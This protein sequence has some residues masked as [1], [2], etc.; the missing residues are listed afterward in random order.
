MKQGAGRL[1]TVVVLLGFAAETRAA[2]QMTFDNAT[3]AVGGTTTL[4]VRIFDT[5]GLDISSYN[6]DFRIQRLSGSGDLQFINPQ[7][8]SYRTS[9]NNYVFGNLAFNDLST[10]QT[11]GGGTTP[12]TFGPFQR[13]FGADSTSD[14]SDVHVMNSVLLA[15]LQL[16][17]SPTGG[18]APT[19]G[20]TFK[21]YYV[22]TSGGFDYS[23]GQ[24]GNFAPVNF[25]TVTVVGTQLIPEPP[26]LVLSIIAVLFLLPALPLYWR[27]HANRAARKHS[28]GS[29]GT[30]AQ[31]LP[32]GTS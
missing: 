2:F 30:D 20:S 12:N 21:I 5:V 26:S 13:Y 19:V 8:L 14:F 24:P 25:G 17:A 16:T 4:D 10:V 7:N 1:A 11:T 15:H 3:V 9:A 18:V 31:G 23:D 32:V 6:F 28:D 29:A 22:A 27:A